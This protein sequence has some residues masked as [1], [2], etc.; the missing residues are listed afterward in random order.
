M[1]IDGAYQTPTTAKGVIL[2]DGDGDPEGDGAYRKSKGLVPHNGTIQVVAGHGGTRVSR[3]GT[4]P[5]M[6]KI[7]VENGSVLVS[8]EGDTLSAKMLNLDATVRDSFAITK[9]GV[10]EHTP[11]K[12]PW[13]PQAKDKAKD[14]QAAKLLKEG[15]PLPPVTQRIIDHGAQWNYLAG[16]KHPP[17]KWTTL[18]FN[19]SS[20][21]KGAAGFGYGDE[22]DRSVLS[23]MK[24]KYRS[25]YIRRAFQV[26]PGANPAKI[27]LAISY[28]DA[29]IAYING[30]EFVRVGVDSGS[31]KAAKGFHS[32]EADKKFEFFALDKKAIEALQDG[33]NILAIEGHNVK[34]SSSDFTLHP[35]LL[36]VE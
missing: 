18:K 8:V 33:S 28:D 35:A 23:G 13:Q 27:G 9:K 22:D 15:K 24:D 20:W 4:M 5:I 30:R 6:R 34:L 32:H 31:G 12:D 36:L 19:H 25:V 26:P 11:I 3:K 7:L 16:G 29:F 14:P 21:Q 1:L 10:I 17:E 2:D